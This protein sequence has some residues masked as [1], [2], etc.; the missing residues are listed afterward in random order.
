M[1][2]F[3]SPVILLAL[4][5]VPAA[6]H[7][8][9]HPSIHDTVAI[10]HKRMV[11]ELK[12][13]EFRSLSAENAINFLTD[14]ERHILGTEY[15][16]FV[17]NVPVTMTILS[18]A[19]QTGEMF[20]LRDL[21]F[22]PTG[23]KCTFDG[24]T[25]DYWTRDFDAGP[26]GLGINSVLGGGVHYYAL[27]K[28]RNDGDALEITQVY[29]GKYLVET[30]QAGGMPIPSL[31][32]VKGGEFPVEFTGM[33]V[34]YPLYD[35]KNEARLVNAFLV[36]PYPADD[37]PDHV[38]L[39]W[40]GDPRT[41]QTIQWRTSPRVKKGQVQYMKKAEYDR[42]KPARPD[43]V[44][45]DSVLLKTEDIRNDPVNMRHSATLTGLE[46]A[47]TYVYSVGDG[48][49]NG[50][51]G[52]AEFT[53]APDG[54]RP[55][56]FIYMG[57][58]QSGL[59]RW[60]SLVHGAYRERPDAAFY[61][62]A[63]DLVN[64]GADRDDWDIFFENAEGVFN[65][66][67]VVPTLGNHEYSSKG[68]YD[69]LL[70]HK[71]FVL[72]DESPMGEKTYT[73]NY[74]NAIFVVLDSN[75]PAEEQREWLEEELAATTATWKFVVYHHPAYSSAEGRNNAQINEFWTP[76][77]DKYHVDMALQG[78]DHAYLRTYPMKDG[79]RAGSAKEGTIYIVSVSG[80][81]MYGQGKFDY[82]EV[83]FTNIST[84]QVL[85][86]QIDGDRLVYR[87]YDMEE[88]VMDEF[89]IEK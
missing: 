12:P 56:S 55:F 28:A 20:W 11:E 48:S 89:V 83:G 23:K 2:R 35:R 18:Y 88:K 31:K 19:N 78:H 67:P 80:T 43:T 24:D 68:K 76:L 54:N 77:F 46:P 79:K 82:T 15:V 27:L 61:I 37:Y 84:Y 38:V 50:W 8:A 6:A 45:A 25:F 66:R 39:T 10:I 51:T 5:C 41:T 32:N 1:K 30:V 4:W 59:E 44:R 85:D 40:S 63:G 9:A 3:V 21:G 7:V 42:F 36:T 34:V 65:N 62:M 74:S 71:L 17:V 81:K 13:V 47:T 64:R 33:T 87:S 16:T 49:S 26:V 53:T 72:P 29:P 60:G 69:D 73:L 86:I 14:E 58:A 70:Y 52:F 57:D 75:R 22:N